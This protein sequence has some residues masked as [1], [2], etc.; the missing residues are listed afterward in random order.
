[1]DPR[2]A[3]AVGLSPDAPQ[4]AS[5][6]GAPAGI[7]YKQAKLQHASYA[8]NCDIWSELDKLY[9]GGYTVAR[10][11]GKFLPQLVG[12]SPDRYSER[13]GSAAYINYLGQIVDHF[14]SAVF[15][16]E[17]D[18]SQASDASNAATPG[19]T[20]DPTF[21]SLFSTNADR[22]QSSF[23]DVMKCALRQALLKQRWYVGVDLPAPN[24]FQ[25]APA[26]LSDEQ[27]LG[28]T[29]GY[30]YEIPVEQVIN[31]DTDLETGLFKWCV[32]ARLERPQAGPFAAPNTI[33]ET[34]KIWQQT[35]DGKVGWDLY[36]I[37]YPADKT[38]KDDDPVMWSAGDVVTFPQI[39][40]VA[41]EIADAFWVGNKVGPLGKEH[42]Q[43]RS[44]LVSAEN[45]NLTAIPVYEQGP[46]IPAIGGSISAAVEDP[47][48]GM[49]FTGKAGRQGWLVTGSGDKVYYAEPSG[50]AYSII[51]AQISGVKDEMFRVVHQMAAAIANNSASL[52]RSGE[53]KSQDRA[54]EAIVLKE[55]GRIVRA[56]TKKVYNLVAAVRQENVVWVINGL[57]A[58]DSEDR[59]LLITEA[60]Q[61][62]MVQINSRTFRVEYQKS[63]ASKLLPALNTQT[64]QVMA[65]EI[66]DSVD[67][68][69]E[70]KSMMDDA[71]KDAL[72]DPDTAQQMAGAPAKPAPPPPGKGP[73]AK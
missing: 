41:L 12:E 31:W 10:A 47:T 29:R 40:I 62:P 64:K 70:M 46:E 68:E 26:S 72:S 73:P 65:K 35:P 30:I 18:V 63:V 28:V 51:D 49:N 36:V 48:R 13:Q 8:E 67:S 24:P 6:N 38:P 39:P 60:T 15:S 14:V 7:S 17:I 21:W 2:L 4:G 54:S 45:K 20:G 42:Y 1:M 69:Q 5:P 58:Y 37:E 9:K 55:F 23:T 33:R 43:R 50:A 71:K 44:A 61:M 34:F 57:D 19:G 52:G 66:E 22:R 3:A 53:S 59:A 56:F 25:P 16:C 27:K 32:V 11:A